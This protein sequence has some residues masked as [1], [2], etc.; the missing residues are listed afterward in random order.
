MK[1][2]SKF[3]FKNSINIASA[4]LTIYLLYEDFQL[5]FSKP[6]YSS[7]SELKLEPKNY[8]SI[9]L[10]PFPTFDQESL[11][12]Y[13]YE[14]GYDYAKG[15]IM[16]SKLYG[17]I[18]NSSKSVESIIEEISLLK[19]EKDCPSL[20]VLFDEDDDSQRYENIQFELTKTAYP[21]GRCCKA[22]IPSKAHEKVMIK[23][24]MLVN[25]TNSASMI[26]GYQMYFVSQESYHILKLNTNGI[27]MTV[28]SKYKG[29]VKFEV[30]VQNIINM[31]D[32][33]KIKCK[34]YIKP[35]D[36]DEVSMS[37]R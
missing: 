16:G 29:Y 14:D 23:V 27:P 31:A 30:G 28:E 7:N 5:F 24:W 36:Y 10:C 22:K 4:I 9:V 26:H 25:N 15:L 19:S 8:P 32:D 3:L 18:G 6:T 13:G 20:S 2:I 37:D 17:W 1:Q 21:N 34:N 33:P 11:W 12:K 35:N